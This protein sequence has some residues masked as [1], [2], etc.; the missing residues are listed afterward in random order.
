VAGAHFILLM[1][2]S[3]RIFL[4]LGSARVPRAVV[5]VSATTST[6][7]LSYIL[8]KMVYTNVFGE[9][10]KTARETRAL[11]FRGYWSLPFFERFRY[12]QA[13]RTGIYKTIE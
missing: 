4:F 5:A 1:A 2:K 8:P 6:H 10:P 11:P 7:H 12:L 3:V 9:T 13:G